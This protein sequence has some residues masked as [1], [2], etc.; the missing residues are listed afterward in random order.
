[1]RVAVVGLGLIGGSM[2]LALQG[3]H[4]VRGHDRDE[5]TCQAARARGLRVA[6]RVDDLLPADVL[7]VATPL[8]AVVPTLAA[9][10]PRA[11][12]AV[13]M[14]VGSVKS[15]VAAFADRAP[16]SARIVGLHPMAGSTAS[17]FASADPSI[18]RGR[19]FLV[20]PTARSDDRAMAVAGD[21]ARELGGNVTVCSAEVHD[22][23]V[24]AVSA[25]PLATAV[26]LA[27]VVAEALPMPVEMVAG[28]GLRDATRLASTALELALPLLAAPGLA[29]HL[30][31]LR[32]ALLDVESAL[33][34]DAALRAL[35]ESSRPARA[36]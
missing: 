28:P 14:E 36:G 6:D 5:R 24:A 26:A 18:F 13:V 21:I 3:T 23:A 7:I 31:S 35:L 15:A 27:R 22:R 29:E 20:V 2:A 17:G 34:D 12:G 8:A 19:P 10:V 33:G 9:L 1:M 11:D 25:L 4:E 16:A 30:A 32:A